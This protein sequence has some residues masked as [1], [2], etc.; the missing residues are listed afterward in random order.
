MTINTTQCIALLIHMHV[1][2]NETCLNHL[3]IKIAS[4]PANLQIE[5][6]NNKIATFPYLSSCYVIQCKYVVNFIITHLLFMMK[7]SQNTS[8]CWTTICMVISK[9]DMLSFNFSSEITLSGH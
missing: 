3:I 9:T 4:V 5:E 7:C 8:F 2:N 1:L 6:M